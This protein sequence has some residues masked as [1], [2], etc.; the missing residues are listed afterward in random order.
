MSFATLGDIVD[1][2]GKAP[3]PP[4]TPLPGSSDKPIDK[5]VVAPETLGGMNVSAAAIVAGVV[6]V[7]LFFAMRR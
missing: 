6:V 7:S 4:S 2:S 5:L 1:M 3:R